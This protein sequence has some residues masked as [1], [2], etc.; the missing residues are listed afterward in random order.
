MNLLL[1]CS[2]KNALIS[3]A[4]FAG[5][6]T[7]YWL[8]QLGYQVTV[9][10]INKDLKK[11]GTPVNILKNTIEVVKHMGLFEQIKALALPI[12]GMTFKNAQDESQA[13]M[14]RWRFR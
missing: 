8:N 9:V 10:E 1:L 13:T 5:L 4:S 7:A 14:P 12:Q 6:C 2:M 3:G 11:G